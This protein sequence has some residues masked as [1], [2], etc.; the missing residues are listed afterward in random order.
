MRFD[1]RPGSVHVTFTTDLSHLG[2]RATER[3]LAS[4]NKSKHS[5]GFLFM[6]FTIKVQEEPCRTH[7]LIPNMLTD[8]VW[9]KIS[10]VSSQQNVHL[11]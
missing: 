9:T 8:P 2:V 3:L 5:D 7:F 10:R 11:L 6:S 4:I 1:G